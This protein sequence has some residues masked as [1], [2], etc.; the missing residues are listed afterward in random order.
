MGDNDADMALAAQALTASGGGEVAVADGQILA[1]VPLPVC[2]LMS[3]AKVDEV[4]EQVS[5]IEEA[6]ETMGCT[7][8]SPF[9]TMGG[10]SL[11]CIPEL[12][13]TNRGYVNCLTFE[14]EPIVVE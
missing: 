11:A 8:P 7:M 9:M 1:I 12:R 2:G 10:L 4:S 14:F 13:L 6:W 3:D 5:A